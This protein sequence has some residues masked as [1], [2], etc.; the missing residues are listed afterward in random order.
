MDPRR[1]FHSLLQ[2]LT[3]ASEEMRKR[4]EALNLKAQQSRQNELLQEIRKRDEDQQLKIKELLD[5][6]VQR[7]QDELVEQGRRIQDFLMAQVLTTS[8]RVQTQLQNPTWNSLASG[9]LFGILSTNFHT[10]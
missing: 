7:Y 1:H 10:R 9:S 5:L 4:A 2:K 3:E 8:R 6:M